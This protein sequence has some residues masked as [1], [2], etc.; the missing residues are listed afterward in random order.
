M[1][2]PVGSPP[3]HGHSVGYKTS[4]TYNSWN[5]MRTRCNNPNH[6]NYPYYGGRGITHCKEWETFD[7]FL[8]DMGVRPEGKTLDRIDPNGNYEPSNCRWL[9]VAKQNINRANTPFISAFGRTQP[10]SVWARETGMNV[11]MLRKRLSR[12]W[13]VE[14]TLL[15]SSHTPWQS[16]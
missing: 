5:G 10:L 2:N 13:S 9:S 4:P 8:E 11:D 12:G 6:D 7:Q 3:R 14:R 16:V 15:H 1:A